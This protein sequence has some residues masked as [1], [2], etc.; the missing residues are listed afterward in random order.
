MTRCVLDASVA[1]K[2]FLPPK[3]ETHTEAAMRLLDSLTRG[4]VQVFV[5]DLFWPELGNVLWKS[6]RLGRISELTAL[7]ALALL[8]QLGLTTM[9]TANLLPIALSIAFRFQRSVDDALHV[10]LAA[11][12]GVTL[13][14]ADERLANATAAHFPVR[15][16]GSIA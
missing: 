11:D 15:W 8:K 12:S 2:R 13:I 4:R 7:E 14:T 10:A 16:L 9:P 1:A 5:P 3:N 6:A